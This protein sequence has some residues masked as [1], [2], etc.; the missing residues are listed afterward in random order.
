MKIICMDI[1][2]I[3]HGHPVHIHFNYVSFSGRRFA[4]QEMQ[5]MIIK[6]L[7]HFRLEWPSDY[8][9]EQKYMMLL[10]PDE[11]PKFRFISR[12]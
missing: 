2:Q 11:Q 10:W 8:K 12:S 4:E 1:I 6:L 3:I 5:A 7:Q 9:M